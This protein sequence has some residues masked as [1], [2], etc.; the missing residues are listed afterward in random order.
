KIN[1]GLAEYKAFFKTYPFEPL[2][3]SMGSLGNQVK[4]IQMIK[5]IKKQIMVVLYIA[6][7]SRVLIC[8]ITSFFTC[9]WI[10]GFKPKNFRLKNIRAIVIQV[11][12]AKKSFKNLCFDEI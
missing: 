4:L 1:P 10:F 2:S 3:G 5:K 12:K 9:N 11:H 8:L 7:P 6:R